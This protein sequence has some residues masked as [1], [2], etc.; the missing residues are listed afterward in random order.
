MS[1]TGAGI[2]DPSSFQFE[3]TGAESAILTAA[4]ERY[5]ILCLTSNPSVGNSSATPLNTSQLV[6]LDVNVTSDELD[7]SLAT[8]ENYTLQVTYPRA[9][10]AAPTVY[11][12]LRGLETFSQLLQDNLTIIAQTIV[13]WPRF[14]FRAVR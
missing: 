11:G 3:A 13:D 2:D 10:L 14:P 12:A 4:F 8:S 5:R 1:I 7:L 9:A 6:G